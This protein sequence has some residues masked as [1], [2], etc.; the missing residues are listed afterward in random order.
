MPPSITEED[1]EV[2]TRSPPSADDANADMDQGPR[3]S[4]LKR[5]KV[6][7]NVGF[8]TGEGSRQ[9]DEEIGTE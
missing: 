9:A 7:V 6:N 5:R 2:G 3:E 1:S 4:N 8:A